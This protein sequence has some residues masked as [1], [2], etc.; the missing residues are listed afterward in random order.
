V[1]CSFKVFSENFLVCLA[2]LLCSILYRSISWSVGQKRFP[3]IGPKESAR[4]TSEKENLRPT[5]VENSHGHICVT[6][7]PVGI[8]NLPD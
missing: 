6:P 2:Y 8:W 5:E 3:K 4:D 7:L 1:G